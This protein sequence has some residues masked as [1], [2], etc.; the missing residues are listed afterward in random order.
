MQLL[1][2]H[3][4]HNNHIYNEKERAGPKIPSNLSPALTSAAEHSTGIHT[5]PQQCQP[6]RPVTL[7]FL[8]DYS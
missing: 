2:N 4:K 7:G 8:L 5:A 3:N 1:N 6:D